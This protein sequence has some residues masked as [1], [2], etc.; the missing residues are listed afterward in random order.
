MDTAPE[1]LGKPGANPLFFGVLT[2]LLLGVIAGV[3][4]GHASP[5]AA[6]HSNIVFRVEVGVIVTA[7]SYWAAGALWLAWH[8]TLFQKFGFGQATA[9]APTQHDVAERDTK[10]E[11]FMEETTESI[12]KLEARVQELED[13]SDSQS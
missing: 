13:R 4:A 12:T 5:A 2:G 3:A 9:E 7:V 11:A 1:G 8:R 10:V 6:L